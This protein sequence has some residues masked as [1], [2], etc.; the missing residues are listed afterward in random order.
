MVEKYADWQAWLHDYIVGQR[1]LRIHAFILEKA[2]LAPVLTEKTPRSVL[3]VGCGGGQAALRLKSLYAHLTITGID[4]TESQIVRACQRAKSKQADVQFE[5]ADAQALPYADASFDVVFSFGSVKHWPDPLQGVSE[6]WR[7]LKP[8]GDLLLVDSTSDAS[9]GQLLNFLK[10]AGIPGL[11]RP[12]LG[13]FLDKILV[14]PARPMT[15]Y[16]QIAEQLNLPQGT[17]TQ[18]DYMPT[19]LF[20]TRKPLSKNS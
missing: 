10:V 12:L 16:Y 18:P 17:V 4:L 2:A 8:G 3:D 5:V 9:R 19:V 13:T 20:R 15:T 6:C 11:L 1:A 14:R 7:V